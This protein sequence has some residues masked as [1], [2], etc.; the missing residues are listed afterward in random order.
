LNGPAAECWYKCRR[1]ESIFSDCSHLDFN[2]GLAKLARLLLAAG[3]D[4][5]V[6]V[7]VKDIND[8]TVLDTYNV[9]QY[10]LADHFSLCEFSIV[11]IARTHSPD[12][13][14]DPRVEVG[15]GCNK[16]DELPTIF[17]SII[18]TQIFYFY[19]GET[20][21]SNRISRIGLLNILR[22]EAADAPILARHGADCTTTRCHCCPLARP[23]PV[24]RPSLASLDNDST[25]TLV[26][27][28]HLPCRAHLYINRD[29]FQYIRCMQ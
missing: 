13:I 9:V 18:I 28:L 3:A 26:P 16:L 7:N 4:V 25:P 14:A 21:P 6:N 29:I 24:P 8:K 10:Y 27:H 22:K 23:S 5:N 19:S 11:L 12:I 1:K 15:A 2:K 17:I 20:K